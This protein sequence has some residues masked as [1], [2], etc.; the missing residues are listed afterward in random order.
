LSTPAR[1]AP[2]K[3]PPGFV[4]SSKTFSAVF[5]L[6]VL[7]TRASTILALW[8][9]AKMLVDTVYERCRSDAGSHV[10]SNRF[11]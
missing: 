5:R 10:L 4:A 6:M 8:N 11:G 9:D 3:A 7:I 1:M 2:C